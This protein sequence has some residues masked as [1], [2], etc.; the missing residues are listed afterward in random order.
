MKKYGKF[1]KE[2]AEE[3]LTE[4]PRWAQDYIIDKRARIAELERIAAEYESNQKPSDISWQ[5]LLEAEHFIPKNS[6]VKF[7]HD[8]EDKEYRASIEVNFRNLGKDRVLEIQGTRQIYIEPRTSNNVY[9]RMEGNE[10]FYDRAEK[11]QRDKEMS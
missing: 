9:I 5:Y 4:L 2:Q 11:E 1:T 3:K 7:Y 6:H 10:E 8:S